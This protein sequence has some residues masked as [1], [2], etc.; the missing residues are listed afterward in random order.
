M[1]WTFSAAQEYEWVTMVTC[2]NLRPV[3][4]TSSPLKNQE[5][6]ILATSTARYSNI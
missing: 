6:K 3:K 2:H 5:V 1:Y 4:F